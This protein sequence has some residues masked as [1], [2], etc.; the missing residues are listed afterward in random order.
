MLTIARLDADRGGD[1]SEEEL[2][3]FQ[4]TASKLVANTCDA[5]QTNAVVA[6]LLFA[7]TFQN[8]IGR[9]GEYVIFES[10]VDVFGDD[11]ADALLYTSAVCMCLISMLCLVIMCAA[12]EPRER[13]S[14]RA[15]GT[16]APLAACLARHVRAPLLKS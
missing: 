16:P 2:K 11:A 14:Q 4:D 6:S 15:S 8:V 9:P 5:L 7:A 13:T 10:A 12:H 1:V 3:Q